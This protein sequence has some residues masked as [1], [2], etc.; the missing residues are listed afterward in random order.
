MKEKEKIMLDEQRERLCSEDY[1]GENFKF[2]YIT[3]KDL[4]PVFPFIDPI[5]KEIDEMMKNR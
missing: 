1:M 5:M 2:L 4:D 3:K